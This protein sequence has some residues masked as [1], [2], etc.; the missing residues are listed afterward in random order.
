M[1][2]NLSGQ[3]ALGLADEMRGSLLQPDARVA[4]A[5]EGSDNAATAAT[6]REAADSA[7]TRMFRLG[8]RG[9]GSRPC[10]YLCRRMTM[11]PSECVARHADATATLAGV[12]A[13]S[14]LVTR[15]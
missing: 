6:G 7:T 12:D 3:M 9:N 8:P 5:A 11:L 2:I 10:G 1:R 14:A 13:T 15:R 4:E